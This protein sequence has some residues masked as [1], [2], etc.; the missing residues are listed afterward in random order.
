MKTYNYSARTFFEDATI[1]VETDNLN[2]A[3]GCF[4]E[5]ISQDLH[6]DIVD[7]KTGEVLALHSDEKDYCTE[8]L[9]PAMVECALSALLAD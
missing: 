1:T 8:E 5:A 7:N 6:A 2:K 4:M 3:I 9:L